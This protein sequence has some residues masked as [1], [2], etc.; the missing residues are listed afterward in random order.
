MSLDTRLEHEI[1]LIEN[2]DSLSEAEKTEEINELYK[3]LK[4]IEREEEYGREC[5]NG[6]PDMPDMRSY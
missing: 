5:F 6:E 3:D 1:T 4:R 2:D